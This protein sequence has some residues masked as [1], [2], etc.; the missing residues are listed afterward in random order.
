MG[1]LDEMALA[2]VRHERGDVADDRR[3][4]RQPE[5]LV[6][7]DR[8]RRAH[9]VD[10]DAFVDGDRPI[11]GTPSATS[12]CRIASEAAMKQSTCRCFQRENE[13]LRAGGNRRGATRRAPGRCGAG[14]APSDSASDAIATPCASCAWTTSGCSRLTTRDSR[15]AADEIHLG[16]RRERD[17]LESFGRAPAQLAVRVRDE[18]RP[19]ADLPQAVDGQQYLVLSATPRPGGV[20][21]EREHRGSRFTGSRVQ[22]Q[23]HGSSCSRI[24]ELVNREP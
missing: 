9:V 10:V 24:R 1:G 17:E 4:V 14:P 20:D 15:H 21:V 22:S 7:V 8:R 13:L 11:G 2:L 5:R 12:I 19:M 16:A 6:H 3:V 18:R 23:V